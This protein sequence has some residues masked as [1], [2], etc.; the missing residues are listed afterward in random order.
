MELMREMYVRMSGNA[1]HEGCLLVFF[2]RVENRD[3]DVAI[4]IN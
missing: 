2:R 3:A 1:E 4:R